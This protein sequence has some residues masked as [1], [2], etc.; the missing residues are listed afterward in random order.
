MKERLVL[1]C[2]LFL[3]VAVAAPAQAPGG[4]MCGAREPNPQTVAFLESLLTDFRKSFRVEEAATVRIPVVVHMI[5]KGRQG[6]YPN[7]VVERWIDS[8]NAGFSSTPFQFQLVQVKRVNNRQWHENCEI[9]SRN[10][11]TMTRRLAVNPAKTLNVYV[12]KPGTATGMSAW[13]FDYPQGDKRH[14]VV[15]HSS[16]MPHGRSPVEISTHGYVLVHEVGHYLGLLHTFYRGC[17]GEGDRVADTPAQATPTNGCPGFRDTCPAPG[18]DDVT[19]YMDYA[20]DLCWDHF[21][22]GQIQR[23]IEVTALTRPA[24]GK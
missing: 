2:A 11:T 14:S 6:N 7:K 13:P 8:L 9:G 10:H 12:C 4:A 16:A 24:L 5:T 23:M 22:P 18:A 3:A 20:N 21:T 15:V 1:F 19:N 17:E